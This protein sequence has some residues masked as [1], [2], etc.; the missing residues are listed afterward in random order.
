MFLTLFSAG[1]LHRVHT[2]VPGRGFIYCVAFLY[3]LGLWGTA[4]FLPIS[5]HQSLSLVSDSLQ[6]LM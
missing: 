2:L 6:I 4:G 5:H 1:M 3:S